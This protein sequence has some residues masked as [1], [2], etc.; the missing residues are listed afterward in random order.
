[1]KEDT[2]TSCLTAGKTTQKRLL[3]NIEGIAR[4]HTLK[5]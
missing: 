5:L 2:A 1:M 4:M 3:S